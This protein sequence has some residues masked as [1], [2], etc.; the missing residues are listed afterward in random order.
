MQWGNPLFLLYT[1]KGSANYADKVQT[2]IPVKKFYWGGLGQ[3]Q[4]LQ[5]DT[6]LIKV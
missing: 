6:D 4:L 2:S 3:G 5:L 1:K